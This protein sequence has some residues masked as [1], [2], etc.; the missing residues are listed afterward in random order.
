MGPVSGLLDLAAP[1]AFGAML[2]SNA[3]ACEATDPEAAR[4]A[5]DALSELMNVTCGTLLNAIGGEG[6]EM[7]IP[8]VE[9]LDA[10]EW[11]AFTATGQATVLDA[12]GHLLASR[13]RA[14]STQTNQTL[15]MSGR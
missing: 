2:A 1:A 14:L 4:H 7:G 11:E 5:E 15:V 13:V 9:P 12:D 6:H 8:Q 3:L 10:A